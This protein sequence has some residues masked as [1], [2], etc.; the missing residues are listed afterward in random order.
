MGDWPG[1]APRSGEMTQEA[2]RELQES[3]FLVISGPVSAGGLARLAGAYDLAV[4]SASA[5]DLGHGRSTTRVHDFVNRGPEFDPL[6]VHPPVLEACRR[7]LDRPFRLSSMLARTLRPR[8]EAQA[9][10]VDFARDEAG[11][12]MLGFIFMVDEFRADNGA[13]RFLPGSHH[14]RAV[15]SELAR[16]PA[17]EFKGQVQTCGPAGSMIIYNGSVWHGHAANTTES[18]RRSLQGAYIRREARSAIDLPGRMRADTLARISPLARF[19][20]AV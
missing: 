4:A 2:A 11:W 7:I 19:V 14:W 10:H 8:S 15:P 13:T 16:A 1:M 5:S 12:T 18:P 9:W 3:G 17:A 20:L 6:Y